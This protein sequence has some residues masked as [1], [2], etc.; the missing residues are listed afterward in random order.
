MTLTRRIQNFFRGTG[1]GAL[2]W[3]Q[4]EEWT[5]GNGQCP[6][7]LGLAPGQ[8]TDHPCNNG[9]GH[10]TDCPR[11]LAIVELGGVSQFRGVL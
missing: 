1:M 2:E 10:E 8:W 6:D 4:E 5:A 7:C 9:E 3:L 11:A